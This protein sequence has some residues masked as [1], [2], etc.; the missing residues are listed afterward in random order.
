MRIIPVLDLKGGQ[1]VRGIAGRRSEYRPIVSKLTNSALPL[2]VAHAVREHF[3]FNEL[4]VADLDAIAGA[5]PAFPIHAD[6]RSA[7]FR[8]WVDAGVRG[9]DQA[10]RLAESGIDR[11]VVGL[12][13]ISGPAALG[14]ICR[15][16]GP[17]RVVFSLDLKAGRP[18]GAWQSPDAW[19]IAQQAIACG[20]A[21]LIVL[22]LERVGMGQGAGTEDLCRR[23][24]ETHPEVEVIAGGG[25]RD[26]GDID[27]LARCGVAG[28]LVAS[29][30][31][32]GRIPGKLGGVS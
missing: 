18:L 28:V 8:L 29:A 25:I 24:V 22:D 3:D 2:D 32:D 20:V 7:R 16:L 5:E 14:E 30:L 12:E 1:V 10:L 27:R 11:I 19:A 13:T 9:L 31:H 23:L 21:R 17:E 4:Y 26:Q 6:L 15:Q